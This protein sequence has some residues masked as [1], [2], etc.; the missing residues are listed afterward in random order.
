[1]N[2]LLKGEE[3]MQ[4]FVCICVIGIVFY[5]ETIF[6]LNLTNITTIISVLVNLLNVHIRER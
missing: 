5:K 2:V 3:Q 1:M 6:Y 4:I